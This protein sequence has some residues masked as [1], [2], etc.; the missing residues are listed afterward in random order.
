MSLKREVFERLSILSVLKAVKGDPAM[1][2]MWELSLNKLPDL[3]DHYAT[4]KVPHE[5]QYRLR[6]LI[7][8]QALFVA[9]CASRLAVTSPAVMTW[10]DVGDSDGAARMLLTASGQA[11]F[12]SK[13]LGVNLEQEAVDQIR[14]N[15]L[16]AECMDA[17]NL[18]K[19]GIEA[20]LI[21][22]FETLEHLPDP[23][24]FLRSMLDVVE[25]RL[26]ISVPF[27]R[28]SRVG[29]RY[30][31]ARWEAHKRPS[32]SNNHVF[33]LSPADWTKL[34]RHTGWGVENSWTVLQFPA[35]GLL[36]M[37]MSAA[38]RKISFEGYWFVCLKRDDKFS[39]KFSSG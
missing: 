32:Y 37:I 22:V 20:D 5:A 8:A 17:M 10:V 14:K 7:C 2:E 31:E 1:A 36:G 24:G 3:T 34:F 16:D 18:R 39:R 15:G 4:V 25:E 28:S 6:L 13:T 21:S 12:V 29:L 35:N 30:L 11:P 33:E 9:R 27:V 26:L 23:I 38:W 19:E